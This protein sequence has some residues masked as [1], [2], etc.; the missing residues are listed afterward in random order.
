MRASKRA[1]TDRRGTR[2]RATA[3]RAHLP[4][5]RTAAPDGGPPPHRRPAGR[6]YA[7]RP[8]RLLLVNIF[9]R[10]SNPPLSNSTAYSAM[11]QHDIDLD[12]SPQVMAILNVT[13]DSFLCRQ[14]HARRRIRRTPREGGRA[15]GASIID[16]GGYSSRPGADEVPADEEW[17]R[18]GWA[19]GRAASGARHDRFGRYLPQRSRARAVEKFGP[20][21]I[22]DISAGELD[23]QMPSASRAAACPTSP[24]T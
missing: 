7:E 21:I 6:R 4:P 20:L 1:L 9:E 13:P 12:S 14:P 24:C 23:P 2:A 16:V 18:V 15:Q 19:S 22:N 17:R 8:C 5:R 10:T 3:H 11:K